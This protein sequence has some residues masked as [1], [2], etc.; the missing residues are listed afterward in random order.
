MRFRIRRC[1]MT[2]TARRTTAARALGAALLG[3]RR[4]GAPGVAERFRAVPRL[5]AAT[6]SGRYP[7]MTRSR[8]GLMALGVLYV[9]SPVDLMPELLLTVFGLGDDALVAAWLAGTLLSETEA[10]ITW[11]RQ[12]G[13]LIPGEVIPS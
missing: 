9:I 8:L 6:V 3:S 12:S 4:R 11:E 2:A 1:D 5:V 10:F 7:G 13:K